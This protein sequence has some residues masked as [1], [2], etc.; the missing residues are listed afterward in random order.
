MKYDINEGDGAFYGPKIDFHARDCLQRSW[1]LGT[2]QLDFSM[3]R[4]FDMSYVDRDNTE[5]RPVMIH[6]AILGS[7][8]RFFGVIIEHYGAAF[9][10]WLAPEQARVMSISE[11]TVDY[12]NNILRQLKAAKIRCTF[13]DADDKINAKIRR[14][15]EMKIPYMLVI[16]PKE[17]ETDCVAVRIRGQK[18]QCV[19]KIDEFINH[20]VKEIADKSQ[21]LTLLNR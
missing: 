5:K 19:V 4:R 7:I 11:K 15:H 18:Q 12:G 13:D 6:R 2:I 16:G 17:Q 9:P 3:P 21:K 1:Q 20:V 14:A 8:E 10:L